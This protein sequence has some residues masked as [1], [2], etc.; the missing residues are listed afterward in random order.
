MKKIFR[1]ILRG[2]SRGDVYRWKHQLFERSKREHQSE[3]I[4]L[5]PIPNIRWLSEIA[6][7]PAF[8][9]AIALFLIGLCIFFGNVLEARKRVNQPVK[10]QV[11]VSVRVDVSQKYPC[12]GQG[13][14]DCADFETQAQSQE[15]FDA[16]A[17]DPFYLDRDM[18]GLACERLP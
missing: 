13:H 7:H 4:R 8:L 6:D 5:K 3:R 12:V 10:D 14:C 1:S 17:D 15:V 9:G 11:D 2:H 18:D 16:I